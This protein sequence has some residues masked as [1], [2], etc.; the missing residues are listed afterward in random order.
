MPNRSKRALDF[1][2]N[3]SDS[4]DSDYDASAA[5]ARPSKPSKAARQRPPRKKQRTAYGADGSED[6]SDSEEIAED[7]FA[8][9]SEAEEEPEIDTRTGR[10][11]RRATKKKPMYDESDGNSEDF[12]KTLESDSDQQAS[13]K[14][15]KQKPSRIVKLKLNV[16]TPQPLTRRSTRA[17]SGSASVKKPSA[18]DPGS[19]TRR[20]SRIA[21][22]ETETMVALTNSGH[23]ADIV[24]VGTRSPE[25]FPRRAIKGGKGLKRPPA[26]AIFEEDDE[27]PAQT[28]QEL[29]EDNDEGS[30]GIDPEIAASRDNP[31]AD[32]GDNVTQEITDAQ[33]ATQ[34]DTQEGQVD[35]TDVAVVPE[36]GDES[37]AEEEEA[38][39][40][41][42]D[43]VSQLRRTQ[44]TRVG[45]STHDDAGSTTGDQEGHTLRRALRSAAKQPAGSQKRKRG[46]DESSDFEPGPEENAEENI[47]DSADSES[48]P[49]KSQQKSD[50]DSSNTRR[51]KRLGKSRATNTRAVVSDE[52]DSEVADELAEE[53]ED[54]RSS[55]PRRT[56]RNDIVF[57]DRPQRRKRKDVDYRILRPD[58]NI[59]IED[60][61][62]PASSTPTKRG[63]GTGGAWQRSLFSTYGPFGGAGGPP[64][65]FGGPGGVGA[66]GGVDSDSSDDDNVQRPRANTGV[67]GMVGMT[68]TSGAPP[69]FGLF[70]PAQA[71]GNDAL[72][73]PSGTPANLGKI[74]DKALLADADPL[75]VDQ[76]VTFDGVG[77]LEGHI[78]SLKEMVALPL[79]YPE[80]FQRFHVTPPRGVLFHGPPGTGKTLMARALASSVSTHGRKVT[81]YM[82]K[83][84]DA[85]SKWVGEAERQLRLLFE[86]ARKTQPSIIFFDEIDGLAPVRSSK[87][88]Q[89][90]SSIVSTLLALMDGMDGRGQVIVIGATNRP[91]SVDPAL[92]RPGR[93]DREFYFPLP[94]TE[95]RRAIL[96]IHTKNWQPPVPESL[97]DDLADLTKGYGGADL[98]ALCTE[99]ALNAVQRHYPQIYKSNEKLQIRPETI[100]ITPK[101]FMISIK[102]NIPSSERAVS[103]GSKPLPK[104]IEP[105]LRMPLKEIENILA[106][107]LPQKKRLTALEEAQ[108]EDAEDESG[109]GRERMQQE[110]ERSRVFRPRLLVRGVPGMGQGYLAG[111]LLN[112]F[113]GLH[114]QSFDLPTLLS[115]SGRSSD[116][117]VVQ[118]FTEVRRHKPAVIYIPNVDI[119]YK[120]VGETTIATF[121]S[122][123]RT[124]PPTDPILVLGVLENDEQD[125]DPGMI[126]RLFGYSKRN[127]F[128]ISKPSR[129]IPSHSTAS[130]LNANTVY[131]NRAENSLGL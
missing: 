82:R 28:K 9:D 17:R 24:R 104:S 131:R 18:A 88:E 53:L 96:D 15:Q 78:D 5:R 66:T 59:P 107:V 65:V 118:L 29:D 106:E 25:G 113:E 80:I 95:G 7:S 98:R 1:D 43:P 36:S 11:V 40:D 122:L 8:E 3:K 86:E 64:P 12:V 21:H 44:R 2:P 67:G 13:G 31:D 39:D 85:L 30:R 123:L 114:V 108:F 73:A 111:A 46:I 103:S 60:D 77:G 61:G 84:A 10:P 120:T 100:K 27:T 89:I 56:A 105:L 20:S 97:K 119:W 14:K 71:H 32:S 63:R 37:R 81:F 109:M 79:L 19:G 116:A 93:F 90:H 87:Q 130:S 47:S 42:E 16:G 92:R 38:D 50:E 124:L 102:K 69:G 35:V 121:L 52:H 45:G 83:G 49:R 22:D 75:G 110:F 72:Q 33:N 126:K 101:D 76:N 51:S 99:A 55:R 34:D 74:K 58:L 125:V 26:S 94:N 41:E 62:P 4:D 112:H 129:V 70:P 128:T 68:P 127:Q 115:D 48:S 91:D 23:H 6:V 57:D 117:V 54:L